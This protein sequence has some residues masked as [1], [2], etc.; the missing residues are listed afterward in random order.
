LK[1]ESVKVGFSGRKRDKMRDK[2]DVDK[3]GIG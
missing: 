3:D 1:I 2:K